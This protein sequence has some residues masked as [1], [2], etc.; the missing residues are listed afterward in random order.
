[1]SAGL[2]PPILRACPTSVG[3]ICIMHATIT[4]PV[5]ITKVAPLCIPPCT[6]L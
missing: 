3:W 1:M 5:H 2:T 4:R 6:Q